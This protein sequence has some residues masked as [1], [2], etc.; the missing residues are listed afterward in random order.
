MQRRLA[1]LGAAALL[2][3]GVRAEPHQPKA[4]VL[5]TASQVNLPLKFDRFNRSRPGI[6]VEV[7]QRLERS[8][9]HL[10]F[11]GLERELPLKRVVQE[12]GADEM[13]VFFSLIATDER[14]RVV[15]FIDDSTLYESRH[16]VAVRADDPV[17]VNT[18][19][20]L[21]A[22]GPDGLVLTTHGTAYSEYLGQQ[23]GIALYPQAL[24]N[25][26]NLRML[27]M[28]RGR[29]FYHA[30]ST[31]REHIERNGLGGQLR[32]LPAVFKVDAQRIGCSRALP[33]AARARIA[34]GIKRLA[35]SGELQRLRERYGVA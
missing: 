32:I 24:S 25:D 20:D 28:G 7:I 30:G 23:A 6:C 12:L 19:D 31:L 33:A 4:W 27:L 15:D 1:I 9:P 3:A 10:R 8:D 11:R 18:L 14:R 13:D 5:R 17:Q 34:L 29:F 2:S 21:R 26:Q 35:D 16:Q 22:L